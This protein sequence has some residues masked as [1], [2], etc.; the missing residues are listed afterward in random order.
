MPPPQGTT[1]P[2]EGPGMFLILFGSF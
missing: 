1:N 2:L